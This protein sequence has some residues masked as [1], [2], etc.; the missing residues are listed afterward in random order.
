MQLISHFYRQMPIL[1]VCLGHQCL[2]AAFG[3]YIVLADEVT[4]GKTSN[5]YHRQQGLF[6]GI[7][8]PFQATRYH[9]LAIEWS[10]LPACFIVD[11]WVG[12]TIMAIRHKNYPIFG[13]QFHPEAILTAHGLH[14]LQNFITHAQ[15]LS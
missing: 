2:A 8:S 10:T 5:I 7:P 15:P 9:S 14:L 11:A 3:G 12:K 6:R 13:V 1:G 4:H